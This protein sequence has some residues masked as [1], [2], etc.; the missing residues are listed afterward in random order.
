MQHEVIVIDPD[1]VQPEIVETFSALPDWQQRYAHL[2]ALGRGLSD[3]PVALQINDNRLYGCQ[4]GLWLAPACNNGVITL[5][6]TSDSLIVADLMA[7]L[8]RVYSGRHGC[9]HQALRK[10][11]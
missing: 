1:E 6:G 9:P 5:A 7:L 4:A 8:F 2:I 11:V 10:V 3:F